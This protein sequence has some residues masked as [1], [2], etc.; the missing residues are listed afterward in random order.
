[1]VSAKLSG[2]WLQWSRAIKTK[3][4]PNANAVVAS[5]DKEGRADHQLFLPS[6]PL[7]L[8]PLSSFFS[9]TITNTSRTV[10]AQ[11]L[12][13]IQPLELKFTFEVKKQSSCSIQLGNK[14]DQY[15][16]F[17]VKTT[18]PKKYCVRPNVGII[19]PKATY[20]FAV[21]MQAQRV[22]PPDFLCKDK[23]LI[24]S[25]VVPFGTT[26]EDI[27]SDMFAKDSGKYIDE[28]K[29]RVVLISPPQS[30]ILL[31]RNGELKQDPLQE[32][33]MLKDVALTGVENIPPGNNVADDVEGPE[34]AKVTDELR[35]TKDVQG[36][37]MGKDNNAWRSAEDVPSRPVKVVEELKPEKDILELKL[38]KD[39]EE[40]KSKLNLADSRLREVCFFHLRF[41]IVVHNLEMLTT[42]FLAVYLL[43]EVI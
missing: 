9:S 16:A 35:P 33:S 30:P 18:S 21:T 14:S 43:K 12:L 37:E 22:A 27:T 10:M 42:H 1:M 25:T 11:E 34:T 36:L 31:P 15:V 7:T 17:K 26:D 32:T 29:L 39:F 3:P 8:T 4:N 2:F 19:K 24:Q 23:F 20:D 5:S 41:N 13:E 6:Y 38:A 28:K 40:L